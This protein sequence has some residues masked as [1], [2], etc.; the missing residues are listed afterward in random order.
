MSSEH[1]VTRMPGEG[2][3]PEVAEAAVRVLEASGV[4][5]HRERVNAAAEA[6]ERVNAAAEA[7]ERGIDASLAHPATRTRDLG[8]RATLAEATDAICAGLP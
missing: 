5:V 6:E 4:T 3:G 7:E 2:I 1:T 8:G